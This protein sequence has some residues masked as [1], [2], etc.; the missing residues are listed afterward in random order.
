MEK[1]WYH[2]FY[3]KSPI[4]KILIGIASVVIGIVIFGLVFVL[5]E[6][7]MA[8]QTASWEGRS[9]ETGAAL[10][11]NNCASCHGVDGKGGSGPALHS[12]YFFTQRIDDVQFAGT[13]E[14]YVKLTVAAGRPSKAN[15]GQWV[16]MMPTWSSRYGGPFRDDQV[17][18]VT[19][20]V[21]NWQ[22]TALQ[23]TAEEDPWIAFLDTP[24]R[25][26]DGE[27]VSAQPVASSD[28]P[29]TPNQLFQQ[30]A[31][32]GCHNLNENQTDTNRGPI[33]PHLGNLHE[34]AGT[35]VPGEDAETYVRHSITAPN[36]FIVPGYMANIMPAGL[37]D[38]M[39]DEEFDALI[40]WL[41]DPNRE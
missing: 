16:V 35:R 2:I 8:A 9:I 25:A 5:E 37:A 15:T 30:L 18:H 34:L 6:P 24:S 14:D 21:M 1:P 7:R 32:A 19:N 22:A 12:R 36:D 17:V 20:F 3:I 11:A 13:L 28:G 33:G 10:Y 23:Q 31:C 4:L 26:V 40:A 39:T 29:R 27:F 38:R 41:L